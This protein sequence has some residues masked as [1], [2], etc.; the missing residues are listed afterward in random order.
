MLYSFKDPGNGI[1]ERSKNMARRISRRK[2]S[3]AILL[4]LAAI[5]IS[6]SAMASVEAVGGK[7]AGA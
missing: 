2:L 1:S 7:V 3:A 4:I 6:T 5:I